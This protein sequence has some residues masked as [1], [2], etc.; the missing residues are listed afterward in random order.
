MTE[1]V[2]YVTEVIE[3]E[4]TGELLIDIPQH[5]INQMGWDYGTDLEWIIENGSVYIKEKKQ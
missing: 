2:K 4:T 5:I 1:V 3:E